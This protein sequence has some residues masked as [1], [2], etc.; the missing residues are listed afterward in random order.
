MEAMMGALDI[1][2]VTN[3]Y[4]AL[5][6]LVPLKAITRDADYRKA[7]A[8][9]EELLDA[10][11]ANE[12]HPLAGLVEALGEVIDS[13]EARAH[14]MPEASPR[15]A[16]A[17]LMQEHG[18]KQTDLTGIAGQGTVSAILAG[19][20]GISKRLAMKLSKRF[21]VSVAVFV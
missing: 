13:Y 11:G 4:K 8:A 12:R 19:K 9:L 16:L 1:D 6:R 2:A 18:L 3:H 17:F 5:A 14:R 20:R 10:G 21:G 15:D 7:V